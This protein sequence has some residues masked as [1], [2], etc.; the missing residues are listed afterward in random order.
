M[1]ILQ[2]DIFRSFFNNT[3][4]LKF[5]FSLLL[6]VLVKINTSCRLKIIKW[7]T[8]TIYKIFKKRK[9]WMKNFFQIIFFDTL[10]KQCKKFSETIV[11]R[12]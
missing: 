12:E 1:M 7:L 6:S 8:R 3:F 9:N 4:D 5:Y 2:E 11:M 10:N